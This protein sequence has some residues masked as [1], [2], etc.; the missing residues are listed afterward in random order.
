MYKC[1][2]INIM[3]TQMSFARHIVCLPLPCFI[4]L[5]V[6]VYQLYGIFGSISLISRYPI[7]HWGVW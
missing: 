3:L 7:N 6:I 4:V 5:Y 2:L 1:L